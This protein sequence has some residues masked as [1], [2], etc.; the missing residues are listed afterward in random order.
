MSEI[1]IGTSGWSYNEWEGVFYPNSSINK[2]SFYS[3]FYSTV[4]VDSTFYSYPAKGSVYSWVRHTPEDFLFSVKLPRSITH[5]KMLRLSLNSEL[6]LLKFLSLVKPLIDSNK[7]GPVLIQLPPSFSYEKDKDALYSF[8]N[9]LPKDV[10]FAVEF[11]HPSWLRE[12]VF[13]ELR[14]HNVSYAIVDEPLLPPETIITSDFSFLRW[15]GKGTK[16]WYNYRYSESELEKWVPKVK[17]VSSKVKR[18]F[19]YFNNH[20][21]GFAV[22]NSLKIIKMIG[23]SKP[24]QEEM[25]VKVSSALDRRKKGESKET[26]MLEFI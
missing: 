16:P 18:T 7:L 12:D 4:E 8:L 9:V 19:G 22:E 10:M 17:E 20:F 11:R 3:K 26:T 1:R 5:D 2:L 23:M 15:H 14:S 24:E 21:R 6:E 13:S 25:L